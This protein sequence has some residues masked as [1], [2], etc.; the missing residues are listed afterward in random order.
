MGITTEELTK[1]LE[2]GTID[3][4]KFGSAIEDAVTKK[5]VGPLQALANSSE[6]LGKLLQE[7]LGDLFEDLGAS[8]APFMTEVKSLFSILDSKANPSG[9]ALKAGIEGFFKNVFAIATKVVPLVKHFLLDLII[10]GL[11]AYIAL[12]PIGTAIKQWAES[13]EGAAFLSKAMGVLV[14]VFKGLAVVVGFVLVVAGL[15]VATII[16]IQLAIV[17]VGYAILAFTTGAGEALYGWVAGAATA[18]GDFILGLVRGITAGAGQVIGAV[19]G[20]AD[21]AIGAFT[22]VLGIKSPSTVMFTMGENTG[23]G[24]AQGIESKEADVHGASSGLA[25]AA[26]KGASSGG[27]SA[28]GG[29]P[30]KGGS[31]I[32]VTVLIDGAGKAAMEITEEMVAMVFERAA[33]AA[34]V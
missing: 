29:S 17:A 1:G 13:A 4:K 14:E 15:F 20:L 11:K 10:Y 33:L 28:S 12:K 18:A 34:G 22:G 7:Y 21:S 23:E 24:A 3:A 6:N 19:T 5:G 2:K 9:K 25:D 30:A 32:N 16:G 8:I 27:Q 31:A 26:V